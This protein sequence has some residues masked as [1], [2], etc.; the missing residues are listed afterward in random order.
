M[1]LENDEEEGE[2]DIEVEILS[3]LSEL[4]LERKKNKSLKE[5]LIKIKEGSQNSNP[6]EVQRMIMNLKVQK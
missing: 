4:K 3:A 2:V 5:E 1:E 6:E